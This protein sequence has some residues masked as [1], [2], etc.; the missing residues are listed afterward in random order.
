MSNA[1][2]PTVT[3]AL[4]VFVISLVCCLAMLFCGVG[5]ADA[6]HGSGAYLV[7][8]WV[9]LAASPLLVVLGSIKT[10]WP[11]WVAL[12]LANAIVAWPFIQEWVSDP[13]YHANV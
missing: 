1:V 6:G 3:R 9:C 10:K 4:I 5:L 7:A 13:T 12:V 2:S 8:A 11:F